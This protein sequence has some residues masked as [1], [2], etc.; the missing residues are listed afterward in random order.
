MPMRR[1]RVYSS[2][3]SQVILVYIYFVAI[4]FFQPK[5]VKKSPKTNIFGFKI[6]QGHQY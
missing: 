3:C 1:A 2:F 4:Y 6:I 5:I